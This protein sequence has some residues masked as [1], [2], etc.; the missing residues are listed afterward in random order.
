MS[1]PARPDALNPR[2]SSVRLLH[3]LFT[4][5]ID[6]NHYEETSMVDIPKFTVAVMPKSG[7]VSMVQLEARMHM[8]KFESVVDLAVT[9]ARG[10]FSTLDHA[11]R[12]RTENLAEKISANN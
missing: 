12:E 7:K 4:N 6:L 2:P 11:V 5:H 9:G 8:S 10:I 3:Q 1:V